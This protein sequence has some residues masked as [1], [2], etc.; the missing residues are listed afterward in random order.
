MECTGLCIG[1]WDDWIYT[2][3]SLSN[4]CTSSVYAYYG[5]K[6]QDCSAAKSRKRIANTK[7][8]GW[9]ILPNDEA[10]IR[11]YLWTFGPVFAV[12][13]VYENFY[14]YKSGI[15]TVAEGNWVGLHAVLI[16]GYGSEDGVDYWIVKNSW[17]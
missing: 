17:G 5:Y 10:T 13:N 9:Y 4:G 11:N 12:F 16:T 15:Y 7:V 6:R 2:Y 3:S 8:K 1:G 14:G